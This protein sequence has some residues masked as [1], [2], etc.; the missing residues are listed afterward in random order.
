[1]VWSFAE[2]GKAHGQGFSVDIGKE[3]EKL[4]SGKTAP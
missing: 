3:H 4:A 2:D 1:M